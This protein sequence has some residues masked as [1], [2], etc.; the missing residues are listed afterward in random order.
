[1]RP[2]ASNA[3]PS[4]TQSDTTD[5]TEPVSPAQNCVTGLGVPS[6][7]TLIVIALDR[8]T[9]IA[10]G[11][12]L[13]FRTPVPIAGDF[14]RLV[15]WF[16]EGAAFG[17]RLGGQWVHI[18]L[19]L[20]A[21]T[22]VLYM[23]FH[24]PKEDRFSLWGF[25]LIMGGAIGNLWDRLFSGQVIDFIDVGVGVHRWPTFNL[26][27]SAVVIGIGLLILAHVRVSRPRIG[28]DGADA[29][30]GAETTDRLHDS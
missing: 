24:T 21:M 7:L 12:Y 6:L 11:Q 14:V 18:A 8:I 26:A 13:E 4:V 20:L 28:R 29:A 25:G 10:V 19:S 17:L 22:L 15:L 5:G 3:R 30:T 1:M 27:D 23:T 2:N 16:N 9:K